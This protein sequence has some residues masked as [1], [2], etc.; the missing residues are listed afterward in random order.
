VPFLYWSDL[1][2]SAKILGLTKEIIQTDVELKLRQAGMRVMT[3]E[4][5]EK[6][7]GSPAVYINVNLSDDARAANIGVELQQNA[8]LERNNLWTP[9]IITSSTGVLV[10]NP[11]AQGIR[12]F[13]KDHVD[14]FLNA[15][16]SVNPKT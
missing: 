8:Q 16:L 13:V 5:G 11:T 6:L 15:W 12:D 1:P 14:T 10:S 7:P 3:R 9:D 2:D 4:E